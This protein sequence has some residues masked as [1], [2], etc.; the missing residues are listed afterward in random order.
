[1][2]NMMIYKKNY[3]SIQQT[4][5]RRRPCQAAGPRDIRDKKFQKSIV[6]TPTNQ[7]SVGFRLTKRHVH[8][9]RG[10]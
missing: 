4:K 8:Y 10:L 1:M 5:Y 6:K 3:D 9:T 2:R 7:L